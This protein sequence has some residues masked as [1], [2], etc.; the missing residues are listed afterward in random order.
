MKI[1][2]F[3][4]TIFFLLTL[5]S[6]CGREEVA[7]PATG[8]SP[9][10]GPPVSRSEAILRADRFARLHWTMTEQ[11]RRGVSCGEYFLSDYPV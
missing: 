9:E 11:N 1:M 4:I 5:F 6:A 7:A 3:L 10:I 2:P 8:G